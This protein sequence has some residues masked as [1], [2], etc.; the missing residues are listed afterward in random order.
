MSKCF[1]LFGAL[2]P[3][4][5]VTSHLHFHSIIFEDLEAVTEASRPQEEKSS[6]ILIGI[7]TP[8]LQ[9]FLF[10]VFSPGHGVIC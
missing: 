9:L 5:L 8:H 3:S 7:I 10:R 2:M 1:E 6:R 4:F